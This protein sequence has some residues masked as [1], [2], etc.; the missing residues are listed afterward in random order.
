MGTLVVPLGAGEPG[1]RCRSCGWLGRGRGACPRAGARMESVPDVLDGAVATALQHRIDVETLSFT[2]E[3]ATRSSGRCCG[4]EDA[5]G[6]SAARWYAPRTMPGSLA[7]G[8]DAGGT[9]VAAVVADEQGRSW[10]VKVDDS[11]ANDAEA[12]AATVVAMASDLAG[13]Q[14]SVVAVGIGAAGMVTREGVMRFAPNVAWREFPLRERVAAGSACRSLVDNDANV[15]AWGE[16][17]FGAG[18]GSNDLLMVTVG[19][20]IGGGIVADGRLFRGAHGFAAEIG[21]IIV[22][23]GGPL[24][25]CGNRG[26]LGA[27]RVGRAIDRGG[28]RSRPEHP[29]SAW[30]EA[31][32]GDPTSIDGPS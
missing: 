2:P 8:V 24:C 14:A 23:P 13:T 22:E 12:P 19:T 6:R 1:A 7:V 27:G 10:I 21:H 9:K 20:G 28:R 18:R 30:G 17:R 5:A 31:A 4:T 16:Y 11:P 15:A 3:P 32:G 29:E 25:G 26:V